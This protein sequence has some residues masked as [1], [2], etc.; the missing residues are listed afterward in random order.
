MEGT[1]TP[2]FDREQV[3]SHPGADQPEFLVQLHER[4]NDFVAAP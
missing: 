2:T 1:R 3:L 4:R